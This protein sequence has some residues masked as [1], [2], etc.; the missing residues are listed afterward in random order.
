MLEKDGL[1]GSCSSEIQFSPRLW[2]SGSTVE[3]IR[4]QPDEAQR[5]VRSTLPG[6]QYAK[7]SSGKREANIKWVDMD[8]T[9]AES[10]YDM[11]VTSWSNTGTA[12]SQKIKIAMEE[13]RMEQKLKPCPDAARAFDW[14]FAPK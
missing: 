10:S 8:Q 6:I 9:L 5:L 1:V 13:I 3:K 11:A 12:N 2:V 14:S 7:T 4:Q